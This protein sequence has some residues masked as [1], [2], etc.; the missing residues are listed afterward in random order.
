MLTKHCGEC[1]TIYTY[2]KSLYH[3]PKTN[4]SST[5]QLKKL[6]FKK[7]EKINSSFTTLK[8]RNDVHLLSP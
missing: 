8:K 6:V 4:M 1:F 2:I 7:W 3:V 5:S